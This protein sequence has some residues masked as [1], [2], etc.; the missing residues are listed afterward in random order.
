MALCCRLLLVALPF[1]LGLQLT[2]PNLNEDASD[3][4]ARVLQA[5]GNELDMLGDAARAAAYEEDGVSISNVTEEDLY[6][7]ARRNVRID[8]TAEAEAGEGEDSMT[9]SAESTGE[10]VLEAAD[11]EAKP[12]VA[13]LLVGYMRGLN[14]YDWVNLI[15]TKVIA[16][17]K[18]DL[19]VHTT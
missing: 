16:P 17:N 1:T 12:R 4:A 14:S 9:S 6:A 19:F 13:V 11:E 7:M 15:K 5:Q 2:G 8:I 10:N 18:A 3:P